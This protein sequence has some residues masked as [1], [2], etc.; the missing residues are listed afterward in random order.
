MSKLQSILKDVIKAT[1]K[2]TEEQTTFAMEADDLKDF[3]DEGTFE[4]IDGETNTYSFET[5]KTDS[6]DVSKGFL[7]GN[8]EIL[9]DK[10]SGDTFK[11]DGKPVMRS[12]ADD[13]F[14]EYIQT[15]DDKDKEKISQYYRA[16]TSPEAMGR[17]KYDPKYKGEIPE[18]FDEDEI[19][20]E[21]FGK[22]D[23]KKKQNN[24]LLIRNVPEKRK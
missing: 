6:G 1:A 8:L 17:I 10:K 9:A 21:S 4:T 3:I 22:E 18:Y 14:T 15:V 24:E 2:G 11:I 16:I 23:K 13:Y 7:V 5:Q 12:D 20:Y 19:F